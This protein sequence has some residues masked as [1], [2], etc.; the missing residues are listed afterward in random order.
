MVEDDRTMTHET[1]L[2]ELVAREPI[3]HPPPP[4][5]RALDALVV[6]D[7]WEVGATGNVYDKETIWAVV[8]RRDPEGGPALRIED[9][10]VRRLS[11]D[12]WLLTYRLWQGDRPTRRATIWRAESD[13]WVAVY[14]QGTEVQ[15]LPA[16]V[17]DALA[18]DSGR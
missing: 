11:A 16:E 7:F 6:A 4:D 12:T 10:Q 18:A 14:H 15:A 1:V 17:G 2:A 8:R 5:R 9:A 3:F 13:G